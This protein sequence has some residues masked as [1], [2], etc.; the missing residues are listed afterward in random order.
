VEGAHLHADAAVHAERVVDIETVEDA[1][2]ALTAAFP[3][4]RSL[5]LVALDV[6]APVRAL[7]RAQHADGAVLLLEGDDAACAGGRLLALVGVLRR[8]VAPEHRAE[9]DAQ[10][11]DESRDL[12]HV[13][14]PP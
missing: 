11:L 12:R 1:D 7:A 3:P 2:G 4:R 9:R 8:L 10:P 6:D 13:R 14:T 5:L